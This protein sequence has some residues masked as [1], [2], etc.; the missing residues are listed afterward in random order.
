LKADD[1][2]AGPADL[3]ELEPVALLAAIV[4]SSDDAI[5]GKTLGGV[6]TS[7]NWGAQHMYGYAA[8]EIVGRNVSVLVPPDRPDE[9]PAMLERLARGERAEH[10]ETQRRR[11][12]GSI[13][14]A[15]VT[16]SPIRNKAGDVVGASTVTRDITN[17]KRSEADVLSLRD[18]L[19][20][21]QRLES[22]GQ[23]V[24]GIA[25]DF[26]NLLAG[27]MNYAALV[28]N[29]LAELTARYGFGT[30]ESAVT[31]AQDVTEITNVAIR[32]AQL[33]RQL[34]IFSHRDV[35]NPEVLDL[36]ATVADLEKLLRRTI[37]EAIVLTTEL[38]SDLPRTRV[39]RGQIEQVLMNLAVNARDAMAASGGSLR[40]ATTSFD[41]DDAYA[42]QHHISP[43]RYVRITVSDT[44]SGM[45][46]EVA[47]WAFEPFFTTKARG[48]GSG[49]GL[50]TV[51]GIATQAGGDVVLYSVPEIGTTIRVDLPATQDDI[52]VAPTPPPMRPM[53]SAGET[54]LLVEDEDIV[55][56][57]AR[58]LLISRGYRVLAAS[59][60]DEALRVAAEQSGQIELLLTDVVMPGRSGKD[61]AAELRALSP[62]TKVVY[63]SGN[64]Q[65]VIVHQGIVGPGVNLIEKPFAAENLLRK[66]REVLDAG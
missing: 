33:T 58:R 48:E 40:I 24:S 52:T 49:L 62:A 3:E 5:I 1:H 35:V 43:G 16:I 39:D 9:L 29:G 41:A 26:N 25:H 42:S 6:I 55:R 51:Y 22:I 2:G 12:D 27:I 45:P 14:E 46:A 20:Q 44:G 31:L 15:S 23:L 63:M 36:N 8:E 61:L 64:T 21:A 60:A 13:V 30:D 37:G 54:I 53:T 17:R 19:H 65:D 50:A 66:I 57:P 32:G 7:W 59:N 28:S 56:E 34:L 18:Q 4:E 47:A 38:A 10:Y 11:K